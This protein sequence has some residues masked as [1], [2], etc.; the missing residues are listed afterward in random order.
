MN[1]ARSQ[2][3]FTNPIALNTDGPTDSTDD[4]ITR[5]TPTAIPGTWVS[6]FTSN[7]NSTLYRTRSTNNGTSWSAPA[8]MSNGGSYDVAL[9]YDRTGV[10]VAVWHDANPF[11]QYYSRS[12]DNGLNWSSPVQLPGQ[13]GSAD[14]GPT[15]ATDGNGVYVI[16]NDVHLAPS[17]SDYDI[18]VHR[19]TDY[20]ATWSNETY[21]DASMGSDSD[22]D[23]NPRLIYGGNNTWVV[24]F[25]SP[26]T[27][28]GA[29]LS[30]NEYL[31]YSRSTDNGVT[32][33]PI[34][35]VST[36]PEAPTS[37]GTY[38][39]SIA[40]DSLG[41]M[42]VAVTGYSPARGPSDLDVLVSRSANYGSTWTALADLK[43][44]GPTEGFQ[45]WL[46]RVATD[47]KG[48]WVCAFTSDDPLSGTVG[49]DNDI[50]FSRSTNNGATWSSPKAISKYTEND[51][52]ADNTYGG[53]LQSTN[54]M[55]LLAWVA[56]NITGT[57]YDAFVAR[58][59]PGLAIP[60]SVAF[61]NLDI[62]APAT[63]TSLTFSNDGLTTLSFTGVGFQ[64]TG[65]N[66]ADF[67]FSPASPTQDLAIDAT[68]TITLTFD[69]NTI[70]AKT[71]YLV[72][73]TNN[74]DEPVTTVTLTG[75]GV[76][77]EITVPTSVSF[78]SFDVDAG[79][80]T[81]SLLIKNDGLT[82][83]SFTG[84]G[85][86]LIG[87]NAADFGFSPASPTQDIGPGA[88]RTLT[89]S[90]NPSAVGARSATLQILTNDLDEGITNVSLSGTG[91]DQEIAIVGGPLTFAPRGT[92]DPASYP[93]SFDVRNDGTANLNFTGPGFAIS[94]ANA[95][96]FQ[97]VGSP[98]TTPLAP[99]ASRTI[100][101]TFHPGAVG[102]RSATL[103]VTSDDTDEPTSNITLS[104]I[105]VP[106]N[107]AAQE[108]QLLQ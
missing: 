78:G 54:G 75:F 26:N 27:L 58:E 84:A 91:I 9:A 68:R 77:P 15:I 5:I 70:G 32:W 97:I 86:Q 82:T 24:V 56:A 95:S 29:L 4:V 64:L 1:P 88:S 34:A 87:A 3:G 12:T 73:T 30:G 49:S 66:V 8:Q 85:V 61:G 23:H 53:D 41:N 37:A 107:A 83:L 48:R 7:S 65:P 76:S 42:V 10:I 101:V 46:P 80:T 60:G 2:H 44:N 20:G 45:D 31:F 103:A 71:A 92:S 6:F 51:T 106:G 38:F 90:F 98:S 16:M 72:A 67:T 43:P 13:L 105:G 57:D 19:S 81:T 50:L 62:A 18:G 96:D 25:N 69:P 104:G 59:A 94:G 89:L 93:Q 14:Y 21:L 11:Y 79:A 52:A 28:G 40:T 36:T 39:P 17:Q 63:S 100:S 35:P 55:W 47:G 99:A 33:S 108:W 22:D 74:A 102:N